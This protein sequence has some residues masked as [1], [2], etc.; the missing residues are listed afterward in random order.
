LQTYAFSRIAP[1]THV[2]DPT[3]VANAKRVLSSAQPA[4]VAPASPWG[5]PELF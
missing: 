3:G 2:T 1:K 4:E 5:R